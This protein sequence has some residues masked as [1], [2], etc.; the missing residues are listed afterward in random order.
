MIPDVPFERAYW[1]QPGQLLAGAYPGDV[2][3]EQTTAKL[4]A[5]LR[6]GVTHVVNLMEADEQDS[7]SSWWPD[8]RPTLE[9]LAAAEGRRIRWVRYPI[10]DMAV[11][12]PETMRATL[13]WIDQAIAQGGVVYVHCLAGQG[14]TG[15]VAAC[16]LVRHGLPGPAALEQLKELT[17]TKAD[18]FWPTPQTLAQRT[19]V[20]NWPV[21]K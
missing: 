14:R 20:L 19:F 7:L 11:P 2:H 3:P 15:M 13:D 18:L 1:V 4:A 9:Q 6:C 5:L 8:Y 16:Y 17:R 12:T 10:P 21:G